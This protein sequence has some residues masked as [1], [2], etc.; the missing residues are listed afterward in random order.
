MEIDGK[1]NI[2][3]GLTLSFVLLILIFSIYGV[4]SIFET[5]RGSKLTRT[6]YDHPLVVSNAALQSAVS[7]IKMHRNMKDVVLFESASRIQESIAK[8]NQ[9]EQ[10]VYN[11]LD[12]VRNRILGD[13]GKKLESEARFL[14]DNWRPIREEVIAL[15]EDGNRSEAAKI[16]VGKG[17]YHVAS[18]EKKMRSLTDYA[19]NKAASFMNTHQKVSSRHN[20]L[21]IIFFSIAI[22]LTSLITFFTLKKTKA[23]ENEIRESRQL[24]LTAIDYAPI[25]MVLVNLKGK[26]N[27]V[28]ESFCKMTGYSEQELLGMNFQEITHPDDHD[29]GESVVKQLI[30]KKI[31]KAAIEKRYVKKHGEIINVYLT[32]TLL[33]DGKGD[34]L[35]FFTQ[36]INITKRKLYEKRII[37]LNSVL[38]AIRD[39]NQLIVRESDPEN[40][41]REGC[42]LMVDNRGYASALIILKDQENQFN[43]WARSGLTYSSEKLHEW[44]KCQEE[45]PCCVLASKATNAIVIDDRSSTCGSCPIS[46]EFR[47]L[48]SLCAKLTHGEYTFGYLIAALNDNIEVGEEELSLLSEMAGDIAYALNYMRL[49]TDHQRLELKREKLEHQLLQAQ[50]M[51]AVGQLAGGVAHDYN[52]MLSIIIGYS[53][54]VLENLDPEDPL[55][56]DIDEI[57][58]AGKRS[59]DIT[60]QLLAFA[61]KQTTA[62]KVLDLNDNIEGM[63]KMLRRLIGEDIDLAWLPETEVWS[64]KIDPSQLDQILANLCVNAKDAIAGVGKITIETANAIFD[65]EY[66]ADHA[67]FIPGEYVLLAVSDTGCGISPDML[68]NVFEPFFTTKKLHQGTG[69]GLSTV[70]G[71]VK[72]NKGFINVYSEPE[73]GTVLKIYLPRYVGQIIEACPETAIEIPPGQ[74]EMILLVEDD[75][76]ILKLS[77]KM[78][79]SLGYAVLSASTPNEAITMAK[80]HADKI[81]LLLTDVV[82]PEMNGRELS[83]ELQKQYP[84]LDTLFMSGYTAN[85][86]AH[87]G[88]LED[89]VHFISKPLSKKQLAKKVRETLDN[90]F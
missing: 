28:N 46:E 31:N 16:T 48:I 78:L 15:V 47:G 86:I 5:R 51:E 84:N 58:K 77:E 68:D 52:N 41:I 50:K 45:L 8:V 29:I 81:H 34:G 25:G 38:R 40:L 56:A 3:R 19:R 4:Y 71:I 49:G 61:R 72:Q 53:E 20:M 64:V 73:K 12:I 79:Q 21:A 67:G 55:Y 36:V 18:L 65:E 9:Q 1:G 66:C 30:N 60:R 23:A 44:L 70:Y 85:V 32:T 24:L 69:L 75:P 35:Y 57:F 74:G 27:K 6:I 62:P 59:A 88:V 33:R 13:E 89:G 10:I 26:F 11:N 54:S 83:E 42:R 17:A 63:L 37:H 39:V 43:I 76:S 2:S 87:R 7:I 14:F 80:E 82:M 22:C 90:A